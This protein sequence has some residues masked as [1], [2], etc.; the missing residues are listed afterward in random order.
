MVYK[1]R[2]SVSCNNFV[3]TGYMEQLGYNG[4]RCHTDWSVSRVVHEIGS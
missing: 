4:N 1:F 3:T 2:L